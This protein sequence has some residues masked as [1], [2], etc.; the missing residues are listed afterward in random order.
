MPG[1]FGFASPWISR[2]ISAR[3]V[4]SP[5]LTM[6]RIV[7]PGATLIRSAYP[8]IPIAFN[9][10]CGPISAADCA[11]AAPAAIAATATA[12][13][14]TRTLVKDITEAPLGKPAG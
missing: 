9:A 14:P 1:P 8:T 6:N 11:H 3:Y 7:S 13:T 12:P 2:T 4:G 5:L 10:A